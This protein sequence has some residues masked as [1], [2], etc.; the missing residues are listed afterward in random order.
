MHA[1]KLLALTNS[2]P[3]VAMRANTPDMKKHEITVAVICCLLL[4]AS[5]SIFTPALASDKAI[6]QHDYKVI[7]VYPHDKEAFTQGLI[8][9]DGFLYESTGLYGK[10]SLRK[11]AL[12]SGEVLMMK[13]FDKRY[14]MEGLASHN[15]K[16]LQLTWRAGK[17]FVYDIDDFLL[18]DS[19]TYR[20]QG[21]G[22]TCNRQQCIMSNGSSTLRFIDPVTKRPLRE[23]QVTRHGF[24]IRKL[25]E[26][27]LVNGQLFANVWHSDHIIIISPQ[28]G[29][30][31]A[32]LD[33]SG[34]R[35]QYPELKKAGALNGI[36]FD[37]ANDRLFITGK[38]WPLLFE[39]A[40]QDKH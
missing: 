5:M 30:V 26:L 2:S 23:L 35:T 33:L 12:E 34:L 8:Y 1:V 6:V 27:E 40:L 3:N 37:S 31:T 25:N 9:H 24:P 39:I 20:G 15:G 29:K 17:G 32:Q 21:W 28:T 16:L 13:P 11:V 19:F 18:E 36:A 4:C 7:N 14:F 38:N 22:L 10:S